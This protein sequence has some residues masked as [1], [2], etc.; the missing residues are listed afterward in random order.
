MFNSK[1]HIG[2]G[3]HHLPIVEQSVEI[4][5]EPHAQIMTIMARQIILNTKLT[6]ALDLCGLRTEVLNILLEIQSQKV[7]LKSCLF[8]WGFMSLSTL[9]RSYHDG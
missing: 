9:Y 7:I 3:P 5:V 8:I 2:K 4:K 6:N 1:G